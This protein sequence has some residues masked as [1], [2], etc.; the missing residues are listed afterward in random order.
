MRAGGARRREE[1]SGAELNGK[2]KKEWGLDYPILL[3][4][5]G[6]AETGAPAA[7]TT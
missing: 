7:G 1:G 6:A 3:D 5:T 2:T 4:D